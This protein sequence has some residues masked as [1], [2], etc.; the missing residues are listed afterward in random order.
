V[1]PKFSAAAAFGAPNAYF[2][3]GGGAGLYTR[4]SAAALDVITVIPTKSNR[5]Q[6]KTQ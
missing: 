3:G 2:G 4:V 1:D 5:T 6:S